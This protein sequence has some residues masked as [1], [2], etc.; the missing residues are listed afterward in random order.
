M[1]KVKREKYWTDNDD[2]EP[3]IFDDQNLLFPTN[4]VDTLNRMQ[5]EIEELKYRITK[6][7][8]RLKIR[9]DKIIGQKNTIKQLRELK[10]SKN[11]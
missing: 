1:E 7:N 2:H 3:L 8:R 6:K 4:I 11:V 9:Q 10:E 5:L